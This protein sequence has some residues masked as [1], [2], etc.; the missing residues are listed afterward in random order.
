MFLGHTDTSKD[1]SPVQKA[2]DALERFNDHSAKHWN[3]HPA[4]TIMCSMLDAEKIEREGALG[5]FVRR[6]GF[7]PEHTFYVGWEDPATRAS[8][9]PF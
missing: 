3:G 4:N 9:D 6:A 1:K 2:I 7:V 8:N 5:L